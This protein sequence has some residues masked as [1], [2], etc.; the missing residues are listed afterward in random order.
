MASRNYHRFEARCYKKASSFQ[1]VWHPLTRET[2]KQQ[3]QN[4]TTCHLYFLSKILQDSLL[5]R[6]LNQSIA[7][8]IGLSGRCDKVIELFS[9]AG[10]EVLKSIPHNH[11]LV[12]KFYKSMFLACSDYQTEILLN[13]A[14]Y[15]VL[16]QH[17]VV[18]GLEL[19]KSKANK[20]QFQSSVMHKAH[21]A[22][23]E[24][25]LYQPKKTESTVIQAVDIFDSEDEDENIFSH[26]RPMKNILDFSLKRSLVLFEEVFS[27]AAVWDQFV[28][29]YYE[30]LQ[31]NKDKNTVRI[32]LEEYRDRNPLNPNTHRY[33]YHYLKTNSSTDEEKMKVLEDLIKLDPTSEYVDDLVDLKSKS[34]SNASLVRLLVEKLDH[35]AFMFDEKTWTQLTSV[36]N[37]GYNVKKEPGSSADTDLQHALQL[38]WKERKTWWPKYHFRIKRN[39][40]FSDELKTVMLC[41]AQIAEYFLGKGNDFSIEVRRKY[42]P[43]DCEGKNEEIL[44]ELPDKRTPL[45]RRTTTSNRG[46]ESDNAKRKR[47]NHSEFKSMFHLTL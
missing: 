17:D 23:F 8:L 28:P 24:A 18:E 42:Q 32:F 13:F 10:L 2:S 35:S 45:K 25:L 20:P 33:L 39:F 14:L 12:V 43:S 37:T 40:M 19:L 26:S 31:Q 44:K 15:L 4:V 21:M 7:A 29:T 36:L 3:M 30:V 47:K 6:R 11:T 9:L 5:T 16:R 22:L 46:K 38:C 41:K 27:K 34:G 1:T